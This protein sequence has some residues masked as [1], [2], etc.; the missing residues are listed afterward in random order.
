MILD[1]NNEAEYKALLASLDLARAAGASSMINR[2]NSQVITKQVNGDYKVKGE[3][4]RKYLN[5]VK[6]H[7]GHDS[8]MRF[9]Q[10]L[11]EENVGANHLAKAASAEGMILD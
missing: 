8:N 2:C 7:I 11:R 5:L 10:V 9:M 6:Q 4:M 3:H 1:E